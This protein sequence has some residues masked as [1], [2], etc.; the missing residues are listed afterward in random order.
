MKKM[1][2][3]IF[4]IFFLYTKI[5]MADEKSLYE[6]KWLDEGEK[7]YVIQNKEHIKAGG[8][9]FDFSIIDN[10]SSPYQDTTGMSLSMTYY[11]SENWSFDL[12]YKQ[13]NNSDSADLTNLLSAY[14]TEVKPLIRRIDSSQ[15]FHINWIPFYGKINT[16]NKIYF[17][18]WGVG[19]GYGQFNTAGNYETF[20]DD[21]VSLTL[22]EEVD[23]G[24][25]FRSFVKF[26]TRS[27]LTL[28]IEY[29]LSGVNTIK[30]KT[31]KKDILYYNDIMATIGIIF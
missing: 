31:G 26:Y 25:N 17:F 6:F 24:F 1:K 11:L 28:G 2:K 10:N 12:T 18:D 29:N 30:D 9:G 23:S 3:I 7:V 4:T 27:M 14:D 13:Y 20:F 5:I 19:I 16:F 8:L 22:K 21:S 15:V